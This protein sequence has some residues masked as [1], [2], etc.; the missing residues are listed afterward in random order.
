MC[1]QNEKGAT[2]EQ[3]GE[4]A[5]KSVREWGT[6]GR[7]TCVQ[8]SKGQWQWRQSWIA[9]RGTWEAT[10]EAESSDPQWEG[11][12]GIP[13][14]AFHSC[15]SPLLLQDSDVI[16]ECRR[17]WNRCCKWATTVKWQIFMFPTCVGRE[18][19]EPLLRNKKTHHATQAYCL[20]IHSIKN[21]ELLCLGL[22]RHSI[23]T[24]SQ[25]IC[26]FSKLDSVLLYF[27]K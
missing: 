1:S 5:K 11:K 26:R 27:V 3:N 12:T 8:A 9:P 23:C 16:L 19:S 14:G 25:N 2:R 20:F 4:K 15:P 22:F 21:W 7:K 18:V 24:P 6:W 13:W 17:L 10:A